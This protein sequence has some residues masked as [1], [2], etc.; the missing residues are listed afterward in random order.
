MVRRWWTQHCVTSRRVP[1]WVRPP[2][3]NHTSAVTAFR[4]M[5]RIC[6]EKQITNHFF[7]PC[8]Q[9][10]CKVI[11][12]NISMCTNWRPSWIQDFQIFLSGL[13]IIYG[14]AVHQHSVGL[15]VELSTLAGVGRL[16]ICRGLRAG[17]VSNQRSGLHARGLGLLGQT[18]WDL[19]SLSTHSHQ[20]TFSFS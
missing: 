16:A 5:K 18:V 2:R 13:F 8:I 10:V 15:S 4:R 12:K 17:A 6:I 1:R 11:E 7:P 3:H 20:N 9:S 19:E 14:C